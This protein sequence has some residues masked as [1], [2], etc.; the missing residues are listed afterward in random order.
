MKEEALVWQC[1]CGHLEHGDDIPDDCPKCFAV[2]KFFPVPEDQIDEK[3]EEEFLAMK[4][5]EY[6]EDE[7]E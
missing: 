2:G 1:K 3:M 5:E 6:D 7:F 4:G